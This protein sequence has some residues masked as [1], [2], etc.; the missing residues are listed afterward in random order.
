MAKA[1]IYSFTYSSQWHNEELM[2]PLIFAKFKSFLTKEYDPSCL[3]EFMLEILGRSS[4]YGNAGLQESPKAES[5]PEEN[6]EEKK[7]PKPQSPCVLFV[8]LHCKG[9]A[10]KIKKSIMKMRGVRGV[11]IDMAEN[12]V[13]IKGIVEPQAICNIISKKTKKR[14]QVISP[15]PEAAE[16]EPIPEAVT[17]QASEPV[18]VE[19]KISMHCEAC[20]NK[21][22]KRKIL[23]MRVELKGSDLD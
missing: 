22:L 21:Q 10:K 6:P 3:R 17:S 7:E 8:D 18:T 16:G 4:P 11:V 5:K 1:S 23:K 19:L 12:E 13:T 9:C 14:A 20:A 2:D 15:L